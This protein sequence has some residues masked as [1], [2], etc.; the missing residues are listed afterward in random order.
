MMSKTI[1]IVGRT[2]GMSWD[3]IEARIT[4]SAA[5]D[6]MCG[7]NQDSIEIC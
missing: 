5:V 6:K 1:Q 2:L 7:H 3:L 4:E